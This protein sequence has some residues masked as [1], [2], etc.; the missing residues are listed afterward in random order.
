MAWL[1]MAEGQ[2]FAIDLEPL[3]RENRPALVRYLGRLVGEADAEDVAQIALAKAAASVDGFRG[4]ASPRSWFFRIATNAAH[5]W[6]RSRQGAMSDP[7]PAEDEE[8]PEGLFELAPQERQLVREQMSRCV[9]EILGRLPEPYQ[10][11]LALSDCE[12]LS[13]REIAEVLGLTVGAA[14]IRLHRARTR[15]KEELEREC[16]FYRDTENVLCCDR[17]Q[18]DPAEERAGK[19]KSSEN[20]YRFDHG[21][22]HQVEGRAD[23]GTSENLKQE[24]S[25]T[26]ETLPTK[27]K[28]LIGVGAAIAA[29][30]EPCTS[31]FVAAAHAAGACDRGVRLAIEAG[32][33]A[34]EAAGESIAMFA[35]KMFAK[36]EMDAAFRAERRQL[37]ALIGVAAAV[38]SNAATLLEAQVRA[39]RGLGATDE[40]IRFAGQIGVTARRG[41]EKEAD[42]ALARTLGDVTH[43]SCRPPKDVAQHCGAADGGQAALCGCSQ[44]TR[45]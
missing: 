13:D 38:A 1:Q 2:S 31:S 3:V 10:T 8:T 11:V 43:E 12:E 32:L 44:T 15:L 23:R 37:E 30:C 5:D 42:A 22:R 26:V 33:K 21:L 25:V 39:A 34:R 28:H 16:S 18:R 45:M 7:L 41:A 19:K 17:R 14:K 4:E 24:P 6:N 9:G 35:D 40:Q 29:G 27:Q 20:A 36:P